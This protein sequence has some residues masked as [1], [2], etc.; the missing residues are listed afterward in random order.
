M[1]IAEF[2]IETAALFAAVLFIPLYMGLIHVAPMGAVAYAGVG[3]VLMAAGEDLQFGWKLDVTLD[4]VLLWAASIAGLG[5]IAYAL[6]LI[7]I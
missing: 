6:A 3:G 1:S 4:D 7:L 2:W 5:G